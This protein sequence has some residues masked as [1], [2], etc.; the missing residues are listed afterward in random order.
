M[1]IS[2]TTTSV[3]TDK[4]ARMKKMLEP[5]DIS[6]VTPT[7]EISVIKDHN[8]RNTGPLQETPAPTFTLTGLYP[9]DKPQPQQPTPQQPTPQQ[10]TPQQPIVD[11]GTNDIDETSSLANFFNDVKQIV[12]DKGIKVET[13][14]GSNMT[15]FE[16]ASEVEK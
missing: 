11:V 13:K 3:D 1:D 15:L 4:Q 12:E 5:N 14:P 9:S 7:T 10:P 6:K 8:I 2:K 16:D